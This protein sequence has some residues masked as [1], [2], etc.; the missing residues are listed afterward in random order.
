MNQN[1][2]DK[3]NLESVHQF[4]KETDQKFEESEIFKNASDFIQE[5]KKF[6]EN[7]DEDITKTEGQLN[8]V[9]NSVKSGLG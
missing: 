8:E 2:D 1:D 9:R 6:I 7:K 5:N 4:N 3:S